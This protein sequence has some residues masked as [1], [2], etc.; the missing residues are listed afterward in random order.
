MT[1]PTFHCSASRK[2]YVKEILHISFSLTYSSSSSPSSPLSLPSFILGVVFY[3][4]ALNN[5]WKLLPSATH[6]HK[7]SCNCLIQHLQISSTAFQGSSNSFVITILVGISSQYHFGQCTAS[8][9]TILNLIH[10]TMFVTEEICYNLPCLKNCLFFMN[11]HRKCLSC[12]GG[13]C[14]HVHLTTTQD[15][16][17]SRWTTLNEFLIIHWENIP[18]SY[19]YCPWNIL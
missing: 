18:F 4:C 13:R 19:L 12:S 16:Q 11:F 10:W 7:V 17:L 3:C 6:T 8:Y 1:A 9:T 5:C 2:R 14:I 15:N